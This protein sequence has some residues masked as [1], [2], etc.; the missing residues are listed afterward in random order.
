[1]ILEGEMLKETG[2]RQIQK[3]GQQAWHPTDQ[4]DIAKELTLPLEKERNLQS[5]PC[6][7]FFTC[8]H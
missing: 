5:N 7:H 8:S 1:M 2:T 3:S 4:E 6:I